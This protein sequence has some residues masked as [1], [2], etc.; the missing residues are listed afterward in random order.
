[1]KSTYEIREVHLLVRT[2]N[3][4][5]CNK[6]CSYLSVLSANCCTLFNT[7]LE[8]TPK[9]TKIKRC[10]DCSSAEWPTRSRFCRSKTDEEVF[11]KKLR[12]VKIKCPKKK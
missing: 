11:G 4:H 9:K 6:D 12:K 3:I 1:M 8:L 2:Q 7:S 5:Y 10:Q